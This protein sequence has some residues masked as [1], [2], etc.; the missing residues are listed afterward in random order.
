MVA[1]PRRARDL[2]VDAVAADLADLVV[3]LELADGMVSDLAA[4]VSAPVVT[5]AR[6]SR[7]CRLLGA[8]T[9]E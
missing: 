5:V 2:S 8:T 6:P 3:E 9:T 1:A 4:A 7:A